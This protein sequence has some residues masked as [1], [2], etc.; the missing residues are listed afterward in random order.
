MRQIHPERVVKKFRLHRIDEMVK[1]KLPRTLMEG[2]RPDGWM[3]SRTLI[4][5]MV[6]GEGSTDIRLCVWSQREDK[7]AARAKAEV[8]FA[9]G[10]AEG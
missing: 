3:K 1:I 7:S 8:E 2:Q 6:R 4:H 10:L 9:E 5:A